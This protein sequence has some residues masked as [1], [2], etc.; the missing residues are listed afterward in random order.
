[1]GASRVNPFLDLADFS[2]ATSPKEAVPVDE[3]DRLSVESGFPSRQAR[4]RVKVN[5]RMPA[6][7]RHRTGR[8]QQLNVK[9]TAET[10]ARF[11]RLADQHHAVLGA[12]LELA[13]DAF[14][15]VHAARING[16]P[17]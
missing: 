16:Y 11:Y 2:A 7:R 13:L 15:K 10:I 17:E 12:L 4:A 1:M 3:L 14:E 5:Q 8:N 6:A 9:A